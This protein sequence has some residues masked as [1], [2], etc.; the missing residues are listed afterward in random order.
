MHQA[1]DPGRTLFRKFALREWLHYY[2]SNESRGLTRIRATERET[3][4]F[5]CTE[6]ENDVAHDMA[7]QLRRPARMA[8]LKSLEAESEGDEENG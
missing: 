3:R 6:E 2:T 8:L 5:G 4:A 1:S 7:S